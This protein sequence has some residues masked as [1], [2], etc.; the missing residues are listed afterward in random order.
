MRDS[1]GPVPGG[2]SMALDDFMDTEVAVA[3]AATAA[4]LTP[5]VRQVL[6]KGAVYGVAGA[7]MAGD[8]LT[9]FG[10]GAVRGVQQAAEAVRERD[11][12]GEIAGAAGEATS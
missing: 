6:R 4:I 2:V 7:L 8:A 3:V 12:A 9:S 1:S 10:R 11:G 5:Q